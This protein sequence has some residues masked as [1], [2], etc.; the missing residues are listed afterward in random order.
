MFEKLFLNC[1]YGDYRIPAIEMIPIK[2]GTFVMGSPADELW[3]SSGFE[4]QFEAGISYPFW[5]SAH[6]ITV[7][8]WQLF[9]KSNTSI[10]STEGSLPVTHI[11]WIEADSYCQYL[12][13]IFASVLP[14]NY[15]LS[16][17]T[18][19]EWEYCCRAGTSYKYQLGDDV[20]SLDKV[21]WYYDNS[22]LMI[23]PVGTK[24]SNH[25]GI[26]DMLG[27]VQEWIKD[28]PEYYPAKPEI[29]WRGK[30]IDYAKG[31]RGG[32]YSTGAE[33][34]RVARRSYHRSIDKRKHIGFRIVLV[35]K[36]R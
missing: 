23:H 6:L 2:P 10:V 31:L 13:K 32:S 28:C 34:C 30:G 24:Q 19:V 29:D 25:W 8:Q 3:R 11:S 16:L 7:S 21:A 1:D 27:N 26:Y 4:D 33:F 12:N 22:D 18:E 15:G 14:S 9:D 35:P 17:P 5:M 20:E 36:D